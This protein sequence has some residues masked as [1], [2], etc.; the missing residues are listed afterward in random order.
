VG[1][2]VGFVRAAADSIVSLIEQ[3]I[4][5]FRNRGS[6]N[7]RDAGATSSRT[8]GGTAA[9]DDGSTASRTRGSTAD[10]E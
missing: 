9:R 5:A 3:I 4:V 2:V 6:T 8:R 7:S 1:R 10:R